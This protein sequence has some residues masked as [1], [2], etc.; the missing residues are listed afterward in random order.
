MSALQDAVYWRK[1]AKESLAQAEQMSSA[2]DK[3]VLLDIASA[4]QRL[5]EL[6]ADK[7]RRREPRCLDVR[8]L[9]LTI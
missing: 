4:Y 6:A 9:S 8:N 2:Q 7:N 1:R 3:R 5:A